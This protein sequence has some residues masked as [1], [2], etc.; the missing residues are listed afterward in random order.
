MKLALSPAD[1]KILDDV[2][3]PDSLAKTMPYVTDVF[4][5][6]Q[7]MS[8]MFQDITTRGKHTGVA[9]F[10]PCGTIQKVAHIPSH[11]A[12]A[13]LSVDPDILSNEPKFYEWLKK[14]KAGRACDYNRKSVPRAM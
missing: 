7:Q 10:S 8:E 14:T 11:I 3:D 5:G 1:K 6:V 13:V 4:N 9:G 2:L 12:S